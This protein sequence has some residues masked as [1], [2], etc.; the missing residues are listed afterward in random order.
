[1]IRILLNSGLLLMTF[2]AFFYALGDICIKFIS[3]SIGSVPI[4]FFRFVL[5]GLILLP[6]LARGQES[7]RG[8]STRYLLLRGFTGTL[9]FFCLVKSIAM[10]PLSNAMVLFYTF[11]L[12]AA[13]F[14]FFILKESLARMEVTL[15]GVG[16]IGVFV[17]IN[18]SSH[19]LGMGHVYGLLAGAFAGLTVVIIR[20]V[21]RTNGPLIIYFY[22]C[23]VGGAVSFP[24]FIANFT[25]P[26][27]ELFALLIALAVLLLIAQL[28]MNQGFKFCK[29]SEGSVIL[30]S[31]VVFT[32]VA[33]VLLFHDSPGLS[34]FIGACL[35]VGSGVGLNLINRTPFPV[36]SSRNT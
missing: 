15:I 28:L 36:R 25:L 10:I 24:L 30:M 18:P 20:R 31:E 1:M 13:L 34:F 32:G 21:R 35:I 2:S 16:L 4:A 7:L 23:V 27:F 8:S 3:P 5:G 6:L 14:S 22:F 26:S 9:A 12:F 19:S 29:A 11:P 17:L 33:G